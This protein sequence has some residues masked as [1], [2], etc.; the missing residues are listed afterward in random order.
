MVEAVLK[1]KMGLPCTELLKSI[2]LRLRMTKQ[3]FEL[4]YDTNILT[5]VFNFNKYLLMLT[6]AIFLYKT[7]NGHS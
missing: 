2:V 3:W 1:A 7:R 5:N 4:L 6:R